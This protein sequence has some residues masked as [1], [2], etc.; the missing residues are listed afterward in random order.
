M[1]YE[2]IFPCSSPHEAQAQKRLKV[3]R[4]TLPS[5]AFAAHLHT[6]VFVQEMHFRCQFLNI[7]LLN[8]RAV[9]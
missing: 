7:L 3:T 9:G 1:N 2:S 8:A 6:I 5:A 4:S